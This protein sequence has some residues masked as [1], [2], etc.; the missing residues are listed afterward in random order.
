M[1][2]KNLPPPRPGPEKPVPPARHR[3]VF[4][5]DPPIV[6]P[7]LD[8]D[9]LDPVAESL[10]PAN[11]CVPNERAGAAGGQDSHEFPSGFT[12]IEPMERLR[13]GNQGDRMVRQS[14]GFGGPLEAR[15]LRMAA[16]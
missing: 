2:G 9:R 1:I 14:R 4:R 5:P 15:E 12:R 11:R 16:K 13:A 3:N 7:E 10:V 8:F 6:R